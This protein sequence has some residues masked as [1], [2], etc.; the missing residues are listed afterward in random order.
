VHRAISSGC[1]HNIHWLPK[2][3]LPVS[4]LERLVERLKSVPFEA[5]HQ[6][7]LAVFTVSRFQIM[8]QKNAHNFLA[9]RSICNT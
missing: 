7:L 9:N 4:F 8:D 3:F 5:L 2:G 1:D 6:L